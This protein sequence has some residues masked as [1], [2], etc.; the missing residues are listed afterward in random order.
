MRR[1]ASP[2]IELVGTA[3]GGG[4]EIVQIKVKPFVVQP[5]YAFIGDLLS[6]FQ[7]ESLQ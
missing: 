6:S 3:K 5:A 2:S 1:R 7:R 4:L